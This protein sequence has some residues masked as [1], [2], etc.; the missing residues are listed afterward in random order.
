[1]NLVQKSLLDPSDAPSATADKKQGQQQHQS[2]L[3]ELDRDYLDDYLF[4]TMRG[5]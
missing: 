5:S 1:M 4:L 3:A 2:S